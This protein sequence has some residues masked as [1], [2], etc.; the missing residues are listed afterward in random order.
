MESNMT[1]PSGRQIIKDVLEEGV[2]KDPLNTI[3]L[4]IPI[5]KDL[6]LTEQKQTKY[7]LSCLAKYRYVL[8]QVVKEL[9]AIKSFIA[10]KG[11]D[12]A[13]TKEI[14]D[15]LG[16]KFSPSLIKERLDML[17]FNKSIKQGKKK[18]GAYVSNVY[19]IN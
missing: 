15:Y 6:V 7:D 18:I 10:S 19:Y 9:D 12:G 8:Y 13:L 1:Q 4:L 11:L 5:L 14:N 16:D 17:L 3:P 2:R